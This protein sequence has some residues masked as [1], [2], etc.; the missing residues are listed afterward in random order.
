MR[1]DRVL[2]IVVVAAAVAVGAFLRFDH[3]NTPSYWLDEILGDELTQKAAAGPWWHW[4]TGIE[5]EHGPLYYATQVFER[6]ASGGRRPEGVTGRRALGAGR[7]PAAFFGVLTIPLLALATRRNGG[8]IAAVGAAAWLLAVSPLHVYYSREARPYAL[9]M[10]LTT[11]LL[12]LLPLRAFVANALALAYTSMVAAP[13]LLAACVA[14]RDRRRWIALASLPLFVLIYRGVPQSVAAAPF[15]RLNGTFALELLRTFAVSAFGKTGHPACAAGLLL[16]VLIGAIG[17]RNRLLIA[18]AFLPALFSLV[19]LRFFGHWYASRYI[20]GSLPA[21]LVLAA[22]GLEVIGRRPAIAI[23]LAA[24]VVGAIDLDVWRAARTE[25]F[26]KIDWRAVAAVIER[27]VKRGDAIVNADDVADVSMRYYLR[28]LPPHVQVAGVSHPVLVDLLTHRVPATW[29]VASQPTPWLCR[30]PLVLANEELRVHFAPSAYEFLKTRALPEDV[31]T[32]GE[33]PVSI[34]VGRNDDLYFGSGWAAREGSFRWVNAR[35]AYVALPSATT[36]RHVVTIHAVPVIAGLRMTAL[37]NGFDVG[38]VTM[39]GEGD[40]RFPVELG[41]S[42]NELTLRFDRLVIPASLDAHSTDTRTLAASVQRITLD[43]ARPLRVD[44]LRLAAAQVHVPYPHGRPTHALRPAETSALLGRL[45]IEP[46]GMLR[47]LQS[48][49]VAI[50]EV[51]Q[52]VA[53]DS[54]CLSDAEFLD[55]AF[56][57]LCQR[58]PN[59]IERRDLL[60]RMRTGATR[61]HIVTRIMQTEDFR[62]IFE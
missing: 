49:D 30:Y 62:R 58:A 41:A 55:R 23:P 38:S 45:G 54:S 9:V 57:V 7:W 25:A 47:R 2:M 48:G 5:K 6:P 17:T 14:Y 31:R 43:G 33:T 34:T 4:L 29:I 56:A 46:D 20:A 11:L 35:E 27:H 21:Y 32:V 12:V 50:E 52:T 61:E 28:H 18:M 44:S 16:L 1:R 24:V 13:S 36:R 26:A 51:V 15:P 8:G 40:Y 19:S 42:L 10:L 22:L 59:G 37:M 3:L 60:A 39:T 53:W